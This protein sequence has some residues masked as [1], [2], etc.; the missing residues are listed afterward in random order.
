MLAGYTRMK[1]SLAVIMMETSHANRL[2][3]PMLTTI[4]VANIVGEQFNT[5]IYH[6]S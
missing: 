1:Y 5:S 3:I 6:R 4:L 2:F